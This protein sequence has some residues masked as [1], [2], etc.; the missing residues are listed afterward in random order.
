MFLTA[1]NPDNATNLCPHSIFALSS[2]EPYCSKILIVD[3]HPS[4]RST[5][6]ALLSID[7]YELIEASDGISAL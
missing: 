3:D 2:E 4:S 1:T 7:G 5:A 6:I